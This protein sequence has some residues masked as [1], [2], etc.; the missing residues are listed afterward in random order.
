MTYGVDADI[1]GA[2]KLAARAAAQTQRGRIRI[3]S[4]TLA[5]AAQHVGSQQRRSAPLSS[6]ARAVSFPV[7]DVASLLSE[8]I[9]RYRSLPVR[10][11]CGHLCSRDLWFVFACCACQVRPCPTRV[12]CDAQYCDNLE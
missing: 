6:C 9:F 3:G 10:M 8:T 1:Y 4:E 12:L 11:R 7:P 2:F 5:E